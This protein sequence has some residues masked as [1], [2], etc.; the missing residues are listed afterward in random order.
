M[1]HASPGDYAIGLSA[2]AAAVTYIAKTLLQIRN[3]KHNGRT[4]EEQSV[5]F[6]KV[7]ESYL[8]V[9]TRA[10]TSIEKSLATLTSI[11]NE[12]KK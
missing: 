5:D 4:L 8:T 9:Q 2:G 11:A 10:L 7:F 12:H 6:W 1:L 3:H